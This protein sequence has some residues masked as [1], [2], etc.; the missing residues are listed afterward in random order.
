MVLSFSIP[1]WKKIERLKGGE[2]RRFLQWQ[3]Q[4]REPIHS[5]AD[6]K[7][8]DHLI[9]KSSIMNIS[10]EHHFICIGFKDKDKPKVVHYYNKAWFASVQMIP[11]SLGFVQ[12]MTL[13][14]QDFVKSEGELQAEGNEVE[15]I[16]WPEEL[17]RYSEEEIIDRAVKR[18]GEKWHNC[19]SFVMSCLC[20]LDISLQGSP[21]IKSTKQA[22][23]QVLKVNARM[24]TM[25]TFPTKSSYRLLLK[26]I[27]TSPQ[28]ITEEVRVG[29]SQR[30]IST[31]VMSYSKFEQESS[32]FRSAL[33][34]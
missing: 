32:A 24:L 33:T 9:R 1:I 12:E 22:A 25:L 10:Y 19:E 27:V 3:L 4:T 20:D 5:F 14:H 26:L 13:P 34:E 30:T 28:P 2:Q 11:T 31:F 18:K 17:R 15:R 21:L 7:P 29:T 23:Q 16:V 8:G 6:M